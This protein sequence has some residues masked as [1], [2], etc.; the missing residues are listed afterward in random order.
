[1]KDVV[2]IGAGAVGC[3][4]ARYLSAFKL[5]TLVIERELDVGDATSKAN[6]A[7]VHSGDDPIPGSNKARFN[8]EGNRMFPQISDE[9]DVEFEQVGSLNIALSE[10]QKEKL[11]VLQERAKEN[12]VPTKM[13]SHDEVVA[14]EP[15]INPEVVAALLCP[16]AGV[17]NPFEL[18]AHAMENAVDNGVELRLGESVTD[19]KKIEGGFLV[20]TDKGQYES[21][22]VVNAAGLFAEEIAKMVEPVEWSIKPR[23]GEYYVLDHFGKGFVNHVLFPLPSEKGKGILVT[24]TTAWNY[25][26]GPSSEF[27]GDKE[28]LATD[29]MTLADVKA[30]ASLMVP[31]I[32]FREQIRV[33]AGLRATP[34]TGDF[35]IEPSHAYPE[36]IN[37]AGIES[38][39]LVSSP[40]IGKYVAEELIA[41][42]LKAERKSDWNPRIKPYTHPLRMNLEERRELIKKNPQYG[43]IVCNCE[44]VSMGEIDEVLSRSVPALTIRA[45]RKRTR[46]GFGKCQGGF[47]QSKVLFYMAKK[48][49]R[50]PL[51]IEYEKPG[52]QILRKESK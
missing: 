40:A 14:I 46:A 47:C 10:A 37:V 6:S 25:L 17:V 4:V 31:N 22:T 1:M 36:F 27:V 7:I 16:T 2:I 30:Q 35:I 9:L 41:P 45:V 29:T 32:P 38:P 39:G 11:L 21:K 51:D 44:K 28:D 48:Q 12:G 34:S 49:N 5:D 3:F 52:S 33:F 23:K 43:E 26:V 15:N 19:I 24:M 8:V 18:T 50:S 13:L 42:L 20:I